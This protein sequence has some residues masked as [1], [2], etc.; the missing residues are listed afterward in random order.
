MK[1]ILVFDL[2]TVPD[3]SVIYPLTGKIFDKPEEG[4]TILDD[5]HTERY[6][7][8]FP[9]HPFHKIVAISCLCAEITKDGPHLKWVK[10]VGDEEDG[11]PEIISRFLEYL[12]KAEATLVSFNGRSFDLP[13]IKYRAMKHNLQAKFLSFGTKWESYTQRY[14]P[15]W[16]C[17]MLEQLTDYG[18][19]GKVS[20]HEA[21]SAFSIPGKIDVSGGGVWDLY[22]DGKIKEIRDYCETDVMST[23]LLY[24]RWLLLINKIN[25][26][27]HDICCSD[28]MNLIDT[29]NKDS[30]NKF[31]EVWIKARQGELY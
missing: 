30:M 9:K 3:L 1:R 11:E 16:H 20:L 12:F 21:A 6:K 17:D 10:S 15:E 2:E 27:V 7:S 22:K 23:Y 4:K 19:S 25:K 14:A 8:D 18:A 13:V 28:L 29:T 5:Y 26:E 31:K 24:L